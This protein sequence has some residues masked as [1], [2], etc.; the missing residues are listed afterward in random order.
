M[1]PPAIYKIREQ[2]RDP[3]LNVR[4]GPSEARGEEVLVTLASPKSNLGWGVGG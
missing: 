2:R 1:A 4:E 3:S